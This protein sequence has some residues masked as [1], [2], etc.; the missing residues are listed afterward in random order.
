MLLWFTAQKKREV[1]F[2]FVMFQF[3]SEQNTDF[4]HDYKI[5]IIL[6][7]AKETWPQFMFSWYLKIIVFGVV[8]MTII[9]HETS[10]QNC[11]R[12][13]KRNTNRVVELR[14]NSYL[15]EGL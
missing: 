11:T 6:P 7:F 1:L 9:A 10:F 3:E 13:A 4:D 12:M 2:L 5:T 8:L 14:K 15:S